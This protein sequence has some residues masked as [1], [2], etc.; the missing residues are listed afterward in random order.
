MDCLLEIWIA[1]LR[2]RNR[3]A[4]G[5]TGAIHGNCYYYGNGPGL[6]KELRAALRQFMEQQGASALEVRTAVR[7]SGAN[8]GRAIR[9]FT[10]TR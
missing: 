6:L 8:P 9:P 5:C 7:T 1:I 2:V 3:T 10:V 4:L